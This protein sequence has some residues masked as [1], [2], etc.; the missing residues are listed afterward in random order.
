MPQ[1]MNKSRRFKGLG[2]TAPAPL[3]IAAQIHHFAKATLQDSRGEPRE[4]L[5]VATHNAIF[6]STFLW[7]LEADK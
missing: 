6:I 5:H 4:T 1:P 3:R 7:Y 2:P